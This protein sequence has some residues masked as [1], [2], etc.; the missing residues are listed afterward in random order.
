MS[1][2]NSRYKPLKNRSAPE[3][4]AQNGESAEE[5]SKPLLRGDPLGWFMTLHPIF[6]GAVYL[7]FG[8][9]SLLL[10]AWRL[11]VVRDSFLSNPAFM[12]GDLALLPLCGA[13]MSAFYR[14]SVPGM[15]LDLGRWI[16]V[17]SALIATISAGATAIFSIFL[18]DTYHGIWSVPHTLFIWFFAYTFV[19]FLPRAFILTAFGL[20]SFGILRIILIIF[21]PIAHVVLKSSIGGSLP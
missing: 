3:P 20:S 18:T 4:K 19:S 9:G 11:D 7:V 6:V 1:T 2:G 14:G 5:S 8:W 16:V 10:I 13:L 21:L 12:V 17:V 15:R